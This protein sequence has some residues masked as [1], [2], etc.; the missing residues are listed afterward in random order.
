MSI[1]RVRD[2]NGNTHDIPA[3]KGEPGRTP[4]KGV[5]YLTDE[6]L[7]EL[8]DRFYSRVEEQ[9]TAE[10][11]GARPNTWTPTAEEV[12]ATPASHAQDHNNPHAVTAAQVGLENVDNT[13]DLDKP[14]STLQALAI[15]EAKRAGTDAQVSV[16]NAKTA[17]ENAQASADNAQTAAEAA[18][19]SAN[20]AQTAAENAHD[21]AAYAQS[22]I[23]N[24]I[25]DKS[26]P[27]GV[28]CAQ[29][30]AVSQTLLWENT[31]R[32]KSFDMQTVSLDLSGYDEVLIYSCLEASRYNDYMVVSRCPVGET[33]LA[34]FTWADDGISLHR[35]AKTS[36]TGIVFHNA[37]HGGSLDNLSMMPYQIYGINT[38][39]NSTSGEG[40]VPGSGTVVPGIVNNCFSSLKDIGVTEF[41]TTMSVVAAKMPANSMIVIGSGAILSG[42]A[43]EI[44]DW[45]NTA[46]GTVYINKGANDTRITMLIIY[47]ASAATASN[48]HFGNWAKNTN[49]V[50]WDKPL[51]L[52]GGTMEGNLNM[53][54]KQLTGLTEPTADTDAATKAYV[55]SK[56]NTT[57]VAY[58]GFQYKYVDGLTTDTVQDGT[59]AHPFKTMD[60]FFD[61]CNSSGKLEHR[62][63]IQSAGTYTI[64]KTQFAGGSFHIRA[65]Q[66]LSRDDVR[67][68]FQKEGNWEAGIVSFYGTHYNFRNVTLVNTSDASDSSGFS[69]ETSVVALNGCRVIAKFMKFT[70]CYLSISPFTK[71]DG[72]TT[73]TSITNMMC[74][75]CNGHVDDLVVAND[76]SVNNNKLR[77]ITVNGGSHILF[78]GSL[79]LPSPS[80]D[81]DS[82]CI[83][84]S[85]STIAFDH[86]GD[87]SRKI[88]R[89][90]AANKYTHGI[91]AKC[92]TIFLPEPYASDLARI[93]TT[94]TAAGDGLP[95]QWINT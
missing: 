17:A 15:A 49:T 95:N 28:S 42:G 54:G 73:Q 16:N 33:A 76:S 58:D 82:Y 66:S 60:Q 71:D 93:A 62:C 79:T 69:F 81:G 27:H 78:N 50:N 55:D 5:D 44:S 90:S 74:S 89:S 64:S 47:G 84:C 83:L 21:S 80:S 20:N 61:Y 86:G 48:L 31:N 63:M 12:G 1:F 65:K 51:R 22:T 94:A 92:S 9:L 35:L 36:K 13:S 87:T 2:E 34:H 37:Y 77:P 85:G 88:T 56:S 25:A 30:G 26:N 68:L 75:G 14:V 70:Q 67:L 29:I 24:H 57:G 46:N 18:Q 7:R 72:T 45:G 11:V 6:E 10:N 52:S 53:G 3:I 8:E 43:E 41:P 38:P 32:Q 19:G 91:H 59:L 39:A 40:G 4:V 23:D